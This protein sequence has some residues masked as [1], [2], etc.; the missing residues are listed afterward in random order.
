MSAARCWR[1]TIAATELGLWRATDGK[2][3]ALANVGPA[4]P[5]EF[6]EVTSTPEVL[7]PLAQATGGDAQPPADQRAHR[8]AEAVALFA[9]QTIRINTHVLEKDLIGGRSVPPHLGLL[10][11]DLEPRGFRIDEKH[12]DALMTAPFGGPG[13]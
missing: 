9:Q 4:N 12:A 2:L 8:N 11:S 3:T 7:G 5:R 1:T 6:S 13:K 10:T